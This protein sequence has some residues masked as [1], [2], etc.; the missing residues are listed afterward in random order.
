MGVSAIERAQAKEY[1]DVFYADSGKLFCRICKV[2]VEHTRKSVIDSHCKS[3]KHKSNLELEKTSPQKTRQ[4]TITSCN[5]VL[6]EREQLN[7]D[8]INALTAA[9]IPLE[10]VDK[11]KTFFLNKYCN[12]DKNQI[13]LENSS[14]ISN[15]LRSTL[16][17]LPVKTRWNS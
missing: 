14:N 7:I 15:N 17:P 11:L 10:K 16:P 2:V 6:T 4:I 3:K 9:D 12:Q 13:D 1:K 8:F 5:K